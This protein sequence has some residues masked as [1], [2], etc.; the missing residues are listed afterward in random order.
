M[1]WISQT[2]LAALLNKL[3]LAALFLFAVHYVAPV[4]G[5]DLPFVSAEEANFLTAA[6]LVIGVE[7]GGIAKAYPV[8]VLGRFEILNDALGERPIAASW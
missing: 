1:I 6:D 3:L 5:A 2:L 8:R 4:S 7:E